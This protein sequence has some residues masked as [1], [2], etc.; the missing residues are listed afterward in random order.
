MNYTDLDYYMQGLPGGVD[1]SP[2]R[3][4]LSTYGW[5]RL[6]PQENKDAVIFSAPID[7]SVVRTAG[8]RPNLPRGRV[9]S[10]TAAGTMIPGISS[11]DVLSIVGMLVGSDSDSGDVTGVAYGDPADT[12]GGSSAYKDHYNANFQSLA[13]G[14]VYETTEFAPEELP[15]LIPG[16]LLTAEM[17]NIH[18]FDTAGRV[19]IA[20]P[21]VDQVIGIVVARPAAIGVNQDLTGIVF[22]GLAIPRL[23]K[24][25]V[26]ADN[27]RD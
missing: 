6:G 21:C 4:M 16:Q 20:R 7:P 2:H 22:Q 9:F 1:T 8:N 26:N 23:R 18:N 14:Y 5:R 10:M 3:T 15:L 11:T 25:D 12:K 24:A 19:R 13:A 27:L 17:D